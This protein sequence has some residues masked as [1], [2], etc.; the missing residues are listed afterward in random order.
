MI[1]L[2]L[3]SFTE[4]D[5][6]VIGGLNE[7]VVLNCSLDPDPVTGLVIQWK[8]N[9]LTSS[10]ILEGV[11][12]ENRL[13]YINCSEMYNNSRVQ[14]ERVDILDSSQRFLGDVYNLQIQGKLM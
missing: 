2:L 5:S 12:T 9:N 8:I 10:D 1:Y 13:L 3:I 6:E 14:C 4:G 7:M 11:V